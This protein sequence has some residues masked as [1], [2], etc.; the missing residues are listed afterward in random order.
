MKTKISFFSILIGLI[1]LTSCMY[2]PPSS[3]KYNGVTYKNA[4]Y[5]Y[6]E[7]GTKDLHV[8]GILPT[9]EDPL[10][11][12]NRYEFW[13]TDKFTFNFL[14]AE[15]DDAQMWHPDVYVAEDELETAKAFYLDKTNYDYY[16]GT[17]FGE[18]IEVPVTDDSE[19]ALLDVV[20][21][22]IMNKSTP[23]TITIKEDVSMHNL[24]C[25]RRAKDGLFMT[26]REELVAYN[27]SIYYLK[28]Y[29][30]SNN[31]TTL[32]DFGENGK[33]LYSMF[34]NNNLIS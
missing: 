5:R 30:G 18:E 19:K 2:Y 13:S 29:D 20:I 21:D 6:G 16:I 34:V 11:V 15:F 3:V 7:K 25:F 26:F 12:K 10:F 27:E 31:T 14:Y 1:S 28:V 33:A 8:C 24:A 9:D 4:W 17:R 22:A 23:K 32:Y